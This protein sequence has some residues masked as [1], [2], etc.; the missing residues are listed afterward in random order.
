[1][2]RAV[3]G[4][5]AVLA[6]GAAPAEAQLPQ[7]T[8]IPS[9]APSATPTPTSAPG[10]RVA[11]EP[12][13]AAG[14]RL[15][16]RSTGL[17]LPARVQVRRR[18]VWR[19]A[20]TQREK[21]RP[22]PLR[23]PGRPQLLRIRGV[24][25][26][27][28]ATPAVRS[29]V[30]YLRLSAVGD[31]NL[32][33][34]PGAEIAARG[35]RYPWASVGRRLRAADIAFGNLEC[36]VSN[37]GTAAPKTFT[38]RG[39]PSSLR[40]TARSGGLDVLTLA[41]NHA[42]DYGDTALLDTLRYARRYGIATVGAGRDARAAYRPRMVRRLGLKVAFVGFS[43]ILPFDFQ[44]GRNEPG[45]AWGYPGR[46]AGAVRR[47]R[48]RGADVIVAAFHWGIERDTVEDA[49][50]RALARVA[51]RAGATTVIGH[52]PHV[53]QPIRRFGPRRLVAYSLGNFVF[54]AA[55]PGTQKTG[56]LELR[57]ARRRVARHR[58]RR[59]RIVASRPVLG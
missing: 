43:T 22:V 54:S 56:I 28:L 36:A 42:G 31:I 33:D 48:R 46:V 24:G 25:A 57:L 13:V 51:F 45:T 3:L 27:G 4:C 37:R 38:F 2:R 35:P 6:V 59:A 19:N 11:A 58:F 26:D 8:P 34:G 32:G 5:T 23:A 20:G 49:R 55:S 12:R 7:L 30:R 9:P 18:G 10:A 14:G 21:D 29:R 47:A 41:N 44:A 40:A 53:L 15:V 1:M 50:E 16:V 17:V 39:R 52:H